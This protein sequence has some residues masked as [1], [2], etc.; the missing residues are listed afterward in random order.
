MSRAAGVKRES[1]IGQPAA[2]FGGSA[3]AVMCKQTQVDLL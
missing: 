3:G 2:G 1:A